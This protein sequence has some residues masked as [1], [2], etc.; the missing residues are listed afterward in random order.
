[1]AQRHRAAECLL[2]QLTFP[3]FTF[4]TPAARQRG[5]RIAPT[6]DLTVRRLLAI[7]AAASLLLGIVPLATAQDSS[8]AD[9]VYS[10]VEKCTC[11]EG[12]ADCS[13]DAAI[14]D[15]CAT[16]CI[17]WAA[18]AAG[19]GSLRELEP[20]Q[21]TRVLFDLVILP[22]A[23]ISLVWLFLWLLERSRKLNRG[24]TLG[25]YLGVP[26][27]IA[28]LSFFATPPS[29]RTQ[30]AIQRNY[31][32]ILAMEENHQAGGDAPAG[33]IT[34][35]AALTPL[36]QDGAPW[37]DAM[38]DTL[39]GHE[40]VFQHLEPIAPSVPIDSARALQRIDDIVG[41]FDV[42][43][44][45]A[46]D[47][48][49]ESLSTRGFLG[50]SPALRDVYAARVRQPIALPGFLDSRLGSRLGLPLSWE[51]GLLQPLLVKLLV[52]VVLPLIIVLALLIFRSRLW[53]GSFRK[54]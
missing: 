38:L 3:A 24:T 17:S 52:L 41:F 39:K 50:A 40:G 28:I 46:S 10:V 6:G 49:V 13:T 32:G 7:I 43:A 30:V 33:R 22:V 27:A 42:I 34:C 21:D 1:M 18:S 31:L 47:S 53:R 37:S 12:A 25:V 48:G 8:L 14:M 26:V 16:S 4:S 9:G 20:L 5:L 36:A 51:A 35:S 44:S 54:S 2:P 19:G 29:N 11:P 45:S 23:A 15:A